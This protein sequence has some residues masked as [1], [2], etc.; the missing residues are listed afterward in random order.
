[1]GKNIKKHKTQKCLSSGAM[2]KTFIISSIIIGVILFSGCF[3]GRNL[4]GELENINKCAVLLRQHGYE[5]YDVEEEYIKDSSWGRPI[6]VQ[7]WYFKK[8]NDIV[9]I[10][11]YS[12]DVDSKKATVF[13]SNMS[14]DLVNQIRN[15]GIYCYKYK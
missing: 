9:Y 4:S 7:R 2:K 12:G 10:A 1:M 6:Y 15:L 13:G 14:V 11:W 3:L 5:D 8:G